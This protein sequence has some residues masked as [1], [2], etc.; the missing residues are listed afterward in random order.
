MNRATGTTSLGFV[1]LVIT[2]YGIVMLNGTTAS[3]SGTALSEIETVDSVSQLSQKLNKGFEEIRQSVILE[4][5][6]F[7]AVA[8]TNETTIISRFE[9]S[10]SS[11]MNTLEKIQRIV[12]DL[13]R[14]VETLHQ[15]T[16]TFIAVVNELSLWMDQVTID[17]SI[18]SSV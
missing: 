10:W 18:L 9:A 14:L 12:D 5:S 3:I 16:Q 6:H 1:I 13:R 4:F 8:E 15:M 17:P 2:L 7:N 11:M